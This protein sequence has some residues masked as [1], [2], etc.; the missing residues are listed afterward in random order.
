MIF[1]LSLGHFSQ[2]APQSPMSQLQNSEG[3]PL[4]TWCKNCLFEFCF[5]QNCATVRTAVGAAHIQE[6]TGGVSSRKNLATD[7]DKRH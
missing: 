5:L 6:Y 7:S 3:F 1:R 4:N 2:Q